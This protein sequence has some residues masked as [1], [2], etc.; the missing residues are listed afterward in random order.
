VKRYYR[1]TEVV[2]MLGLEEGFLERLQRETSIAEETGGKFAAA[3][4]DRIRIARQ[5]EEDLGLDAAGIE[6][7]LLLRERLLTER[8][9]L[10][11]VIVALREKVTRGG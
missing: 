3:D 10:L 1:R 5:L 11:S 7:A 4:V 8:R 6:V 2:E 9:E